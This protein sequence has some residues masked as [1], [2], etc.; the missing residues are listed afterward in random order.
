MKRSIT[1]KYAIDYFKKQGE[2][3]TEEDAIE[4]LDIMYF[5]PKNIVK[6]LKVD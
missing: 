5:L 6:D 2:D 1:P 4:I 3:I